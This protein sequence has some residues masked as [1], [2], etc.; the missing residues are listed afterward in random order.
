MDCTYL[1]P[2]REHVFKMAS[3][4]LHMQLNKKISGKSGVFVRSHS[5]YTQGFTQRIKVAHWNMY[6]YNKPSWLWI[7]RKARDVRNMTKLWQER[8]PH[9]NKAIYHLCFDI[10]QI[11]IKPRNVNYNFSLSNLPYPWILLKKEDNTLA[12]MQQIDRKRKFSNVCNCISNNLKFPFRCLDS[13]KLLGH[14]FADSTDENSSAV[15]RLHDFLCERKRLNWDKN[16]RIVFYFYPPVKYASCKMRTHNSQSYYLW[17]QRGWYF[18][19]GRHP[20]VA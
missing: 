18:W 17:Q 6:I 3:D 12:D 11:C 16:N 9:A 5:F 7:R 14:L 13:S 8:T 10:R 20:V 2:A 1:G 4:N 15:R 19:T